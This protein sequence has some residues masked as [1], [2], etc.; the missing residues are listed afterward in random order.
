MHDNESFVLDDSYSLQ[1]KNGT[2]IFPVFTD[3]IG[4]IS[5]AAKGVSRS[6]AE[7]A[8]IALRLSL[9]ELLETECATAVLDEPFAFLDEEAEQKLMEKLTDSGTVQVFLLT[10]RKMTENPNNFNLV[11]IDL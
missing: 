3:G 1:Y 2:R 4:R 11:N 10:S 5:R 9:T 6:L 7:S 8:A